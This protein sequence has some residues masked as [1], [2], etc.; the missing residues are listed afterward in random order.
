[1]AI[2]KAKRKSNFTQ[3]P[4]ETLQDVNLS[5]E[6]RGVLGLLL[7]KPDDWVIHKSWI[8]K[9][10]PKCGK[11]R[12][13]RILKELEDRGY[14]QKDP[15][16]GSKGRFEGMDWLLYETPHR[17]TENPT[18][19]NTE[20]GKPATTNIDLFTNTGVDTNT[21]QGNVSAAYR[22]DKV[23]YLPVWK[24]IQT[25]LEK[26]YSGL[27]LHTP[28]NLDIDAIKWGLE[29]NPNLFNE[30]ICFA[31]FGLIESKLG[32]AKK[33]LNPLQRAM[34][35][36]IPAENWEVMLDERLDVMGVF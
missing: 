10:G 14:L 26:Q 17:S 36:K 3:I 11:D 24:N 5:F 19:E 20:S 6:A 2:R 13:T 28:S 1:M 25:Y 22:S 9:Q 34:V 35:S 27:Q 15:V 18:P 32:E 12:L 16:R 29:I 4:N 31:L 21:L 7:S 33:V 8:Q 23:K 30:A